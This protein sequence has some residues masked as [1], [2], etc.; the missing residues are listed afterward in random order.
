MP[1]INIKMAGP[2]PTSEQKEQIIQEV[3]DTMVRVLGKNKERVMVMLETLKDDDIGVG[4][5]SIKKI[6]EESK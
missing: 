3:T 5:K 2:E 4:G 6:K 1:F